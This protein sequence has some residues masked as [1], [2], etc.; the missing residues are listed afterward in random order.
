MDELDVTIHA[1]QPLIFK[2]IGMAL[3]TTLAGY[4]LDVANDD[5]RGARVFNMSETV[6]LGTIHDVIIDQDSG[7]IDYLV[8]SGANGMVLLPADRV[9]VF[10]DS[11]AADLDPDQFATLPSI[12]LAALDNPDAWDT[13]L[14]QYREAWQ[15]AGIQ[16]REPDLV[17]PRPSDDSEPTLW[18]RF[19]EAVR[20]NRG[21]GNR[22]EGEIERAEGPR[23][24][25]KIA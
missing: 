17:A 19:C 24:G 12:D 22:I 15:K 9:R 20:R 14:D 16:T 11:F 21:E 1:S 2:E 10:G 8:V 5:I 25:R 7:R 18:D 23:P 6:E 3:Y 4:H 13:Y